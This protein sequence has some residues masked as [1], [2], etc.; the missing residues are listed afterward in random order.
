[1][2]RLRARIVL[3][4]GRQDA[5]AVREGL[6]YS[7]ATNL[8]SANECIDTDAGHFSPTG[9]T[10]QTPC[11]AGTVQPRSKQPKCDNCAAGKFINASGLTECHACAP[12]SYCPEGA[13]APLPCSEGTYSNMTGLG[14]A[15]DCT[16]TDLLMAPA[17]IKI[18]GLPSCAFGAIEL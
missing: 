5:A 4:R 18:V 1:M 15:A 9:S 11:S 10:E 3:P 12:G 8:T 13:S 14:T 6:S 2:R 17:H 16:G 7:N